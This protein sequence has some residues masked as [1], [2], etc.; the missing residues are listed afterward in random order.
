MDEFDDFFAR[1]DRKKKGGKKSKKTSAQEKSDEIVQQNQNNKATD[2][3][4]EWKDFE[5]KK[6]IDLTGLKIEV[7]NTVVDDEEDDQNEKEAN[8]GDESDGENSKSK[9]GPYKLV[10]QSDAKGPELSKIAFPS[11]ADAANSAKLSAK[12]DDGFEKVKTSKNGPKWNADNTSDG[13]YVPPALRENRFS[14]LRKD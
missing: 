12:D 13:K 9:S 8:S 3:D 14:S 7:I 11:L 5:E 4:S 10:N 1:K 2:E 6:D